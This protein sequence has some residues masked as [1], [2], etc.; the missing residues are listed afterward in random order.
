MNLFHCSP[1]NWGSLAPPGGWG[2]WAQYEAGSLFSLAIQGND[3]GSGA[4]QSPLNLFQTATCPDTHEIITRRIRSIDCNR[5]DVT[6]DISPYSLRA[7]FPVDDTLCVRPGI[8]MS[9]VG[10]PFVLVWME[11]HARA[12]HVIDGRRYDAELQMVHLGTGNATTEMATV[13]L[14]I[15]ASA[16]SDNRE[17]QWYL[18]QWQIVANGKSAQ[19]CARSRDLQSYFPPLDDPIEFQLVHEEDQAERELLIINKCKPDRFG[20]GCEPLLP[21][22]KMF[23]YNLWPDIWYFGY[24]GS[25]A[26]P[27]CSPIVH[28]RV[29]D[30]PL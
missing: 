23:P 20:H 18:D 6:F 12:E 19:S 4:S 2:E 9:G 3:C 28:W 1:N 25:I 14:L 16:R 17:F 26:S 8:V 21:R 15:E 24:D 30:E 5:S 7:Y 29:L 22:K 11:L 13:S 27:P 10:D